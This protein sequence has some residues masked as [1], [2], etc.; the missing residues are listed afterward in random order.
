MQVRF[1]VLP[2]NDVQILVLGLAHL[3]GVVVGLQAV[4]VLEEFQAPKLL[5]VWGP[6]C[7]RS[8]LSGLLLKTT[9][10]ASSSVIRWR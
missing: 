8:L 3:E 9:S 5:Q 1:A 10:L 6:S 7:G 2:Q 4:E